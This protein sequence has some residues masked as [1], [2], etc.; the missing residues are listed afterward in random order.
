MAGPSWHG[1]GQAEFRGALD[2]SVDLPL[3]S[4]GSR[5]LAALADLLII[6]AMA[7]A[8]VFGFFSL[9]S[10]LGEEASP[11]VFAGLL[12]AIFLLNWGFFVICEQLMEGGSPGKRLLRLRVV[13][14]DGRAPG[15]LASLIR[16]LLR[17]V[18]ILPS[19]YGI[20]AV[21]ILATGT[22]QRLGDLAAGTLVVAEAASAARGASATASRDWPSGLDQDEIT[23]IELYFARLADLPEPARE[24]LASKMRTW[25]ELTHPDLAR[26]GRGEASAEQAVRKMFAGE[27]E[28]GAAS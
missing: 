17:N 3:A 18:D 6:V 10:V 25:L 12:V 2:V 1:A 19:G 22:S 9:A 13:S 26:R 11:W 23:L 14:Q 5:G 4:L 16:N 27:V 21:S 20:G 7:I 24:G 28:P 15:L 8:L